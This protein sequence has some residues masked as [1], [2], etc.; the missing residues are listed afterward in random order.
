MRL[1]IFIEK[2]FNRV[3]YGQLN[4]LPKLLRLHQRLQ[5]LM[6]QILFHLRVDRLLARDEFDG[7]HG[8]WDTW[9]ISFAWRVSGNLPKQDGTRRG[10]R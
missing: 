4:I 5:S 8:K 7:T 6:I 2:N 10:R 1:P 9:N 3:N